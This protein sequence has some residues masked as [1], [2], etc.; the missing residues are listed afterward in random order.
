MT[1]METLKD[2][3]D[4]IHP[5]TRC[6]LKNI[7]R[8]GFHPTG[9]RDFAL[10]VRDDLNIE[11]TIASKFLTST[12]TLSDIAKNFCYGAIVGSTMYHITEN[13]IKQI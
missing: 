3:N 7:V 2:I 12:G 5:L 1:K 10:A 4:R 8:M 6:S 13:L 11:G 9:I